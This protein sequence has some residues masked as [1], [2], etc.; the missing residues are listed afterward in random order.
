MLARSEDRGLSS[1]AA[2][3]LTLG[4]ITGGPRDVVRKPGLCRALTESVLVMATR[5]S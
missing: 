2:I 5:A 1:A 4:L 3:L